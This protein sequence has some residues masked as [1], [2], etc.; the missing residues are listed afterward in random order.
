[1][2]SPHDT[3][4]RRQA[5]WPWLLMPLIVLLV[6]WTLHD[7]QQTAKSDSQARTHETTTAEEP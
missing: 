7:F 3:K 1:M 4:E 6:A 2:P 5:M